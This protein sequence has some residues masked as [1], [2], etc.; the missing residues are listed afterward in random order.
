MSSLISCLQQA[1]LRIKSPARL[2]TKVFCIGANKTGTTSL[3]S[4]FA[5]LGYRLAPQIPAERMIGDWAKRD[6][7]RIIRF[8]RPYQAFQ[9][10]PFSLDFTYQALDASFPGSKFILTVRNSAEEWLDSYRRF[11]RGLLQGRDET[12]RENLGSIPYNYQGFFLESLD[13]IYGK[14]TPPFD[15]DTYIKSYHQYIEQVE[16]YFRHQP[17]K[18]LIC[19]LADRETGRKLARFLKLETESVIVPH[20]NASR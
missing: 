4:V 13:L 17:E 8:C 12:S 6:F 5:G 7:R 19:N 14:E 15:R 1:F 2:R 11:T 18:L 9:D 20:L 3:A 10:M 16:L